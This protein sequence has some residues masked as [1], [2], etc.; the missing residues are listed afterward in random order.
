MSLLVP[1]LICHFLHAK[2]RD[3]GPELQVS[4]VPSSQPVILCTQNSV[5]STRIC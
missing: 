2:Q 4:M 1:D 5:L 3:L